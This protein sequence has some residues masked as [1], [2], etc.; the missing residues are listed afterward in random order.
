MFQIGQTYERPELLKFIGSSQPQSGILLNKE[1]S[2]TIIITIGGRHTKRVSYSDF[3][4]D[5]GVWE[6]TG[7]GEKGDQNPDRFANSLLRETDKK[8]LLFSTREPN[9]AEVRERGHHKKLYRFEGM[10]KFRNWTIH[11]PTEGKRKETN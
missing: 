10:F 2:D 8:I 9:A 6:Y 3:Q 1:G 11:I 5:D 4:N 7:Q